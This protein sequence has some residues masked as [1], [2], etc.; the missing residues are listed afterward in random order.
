MNN[1]RWCDVVRGEKSK[2]YQINKLTSFFRFF[3]LAG[4]PSF[5]FFFASFFFFGR[6]FFLDGTSLSDIS[7]GSSRRGGRESERLK[8]GRKTAIR[9][10]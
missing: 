3:V 4:F 5:S 7:G 1:K 9:I 8:R 2:A 6:P 10:R